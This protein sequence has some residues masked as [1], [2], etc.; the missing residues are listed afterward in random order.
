MY[1]FSFPNSLAGHAALEEAEV[2]VITTPGFEVIGRPEGGSFLI[3]LVSIRSVIRLPVSQLDAYMSAHTF[4]A[5]GHCSGQV[6]ILHAIAKVWDHLPSCE[7]YFSHVVED[8]EAN[9]S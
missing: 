2:R 7:L 9:I 8:V 6:S 1:P 5:T 4:A 3:K